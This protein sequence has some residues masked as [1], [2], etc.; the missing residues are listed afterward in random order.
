MTAPIERRRHRR[1]FGRDLLVLVPEGSSYPVRDISPGGLC[2]QGTPFAI[3]ELVGITLSSAANPFDAV[4][5]SCR[6]V[7]ISTTGSHMEFCPV[8]MPLLTFIIQHIGKEL[9]VEPYYFGKRHPL[10]SQS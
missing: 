3:G 4:D 10:S 9:G 8:T 6:V 7:A 2:L 5:A 1:H